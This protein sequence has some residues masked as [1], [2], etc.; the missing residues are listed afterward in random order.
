MAST[1][2]SGQEGS[3]AY[4]FLSNAESL[5]G[6]SPQSKHE[7]FL[8]KIEW[9]DKTLPFKKKYFQIS[10]T[11]LSICPSVSVS[12]S[13]EY[14][15]S[16]ESAKTPTVDNYGISCSKEKFLPNP[17]MLSNISVLFNTIVVLR[18]SPVNAKYLY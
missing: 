11:Q 6:L 5:F 3:Y 1:N 10:C 14:L 9:I 4:N 7:Q 15:I 18:I 17:R 16:E 12:S 2:G 8:E 13:G